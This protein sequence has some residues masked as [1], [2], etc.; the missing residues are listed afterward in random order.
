MRNTIKTIIYD[1]VIIL[2]VIQFTAWYWDAQC[3]F[4][5]MYAEDHVCVI[6]TFVTDSLILV[7]SGVTDDLEMFCKKLIHKLLRRKGD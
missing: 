5:L 1:A 4:P 7:A 2:F 6:T 3:V